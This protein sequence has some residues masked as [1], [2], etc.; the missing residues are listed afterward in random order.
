M[1]YMDIAAVFVR[2]L[3]VDTRMDIEA[4]KSTNVD[5]F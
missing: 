4:D 3:A 1:A 5:I 2:V